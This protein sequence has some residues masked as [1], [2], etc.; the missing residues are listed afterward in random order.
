MRALLL[1][2]A[3]EEI[4]HRAVAF[5]VLRQVSPSYALRVAGLAMATALL[6]GFWLGGDRDA[7]PPGAAA[8][9]RA[10][11]HRATG[12]S[13][14][15][16][17]QATGVFVPGIRE[18][19]RPGFHPSQKD[20]DG[21]RRRVPRQRGPGLTERVDERTTTSSSSAPA[22]PASAWPSASS[23]PASHDFVILEQADG[24]GRHL[25]RQPLPR[26]RA[27]TWSRTSTRS[28]SS[29][30][31]AGRAPSPRR[32]RSSRTSSTART[33]TACARTSAS[34]RRVTRRLVRRARGG[35][36]RCRRPTGG[37][38]RARV[39]R[40]GGRGPLSRPRYPDIPGLSSFEGKI[41]PL[42][43]L[44]RRR[45]RSRARRSP[46]IGTGASAIQIVPAIAPEVGELFV[47][48]RTPPWIMPKP[49]RPHPRPRA[50]ALPPRRRPSQ[51][52]ARARH[53]LAARA[54]G[55]RLRRR[56]PHPGARRAA[57]RAATSPRSVADPAPAR[58]LAPSY[59]MGCKRVLLTNDY[60]PALQRENVE[61]VTEG[62]R[63][64][65]RP[66]RRDDATAASA[67]STPRARDGL[68]GGR[69]TSAPVR[70]RGRGGRDL[71]EAWRDGAEAYLGTTISGFP[72]LFLLV[73][74]NTGLGHTSMVFMIESQIAYV[75]DAIRDDA[76]ARARS[77][78][79][80]APDAQARYNELQARLAR[81]VWST[82]LHELVPD[83]RAGRTRRSGRAS[84][85]SSACARG[86]SIPRTTK[87][88]RSA[89]RPR[90]A[91]VRARAR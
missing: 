23:R 84:P 22:S 35:L 74:P 55:A 86:A 83:A 77:S 34:A 2:H 36:G 19:L 45:T 28:R 53:L 47:F 5:D 13:R 87:W 29:Q 65:R 56:A 17:A 60:Y 76:R 59:T 63:E 20:T 89:P 49:D 68:R 48:Q 10:R 70:V 72:N 37:R 27:A 43:A 58:K 39:A 30:T 80:S 46:S 66:R 4:E 32:R 40:L 82:G 42:G 8:S 90:L 14:A 51:K 31:R 44:G 79:T 25:A 3:A 9:P 67:R 78:S 50:R 64:V 71:D 6:G 52:L 33:S 75:L 18:Y 21:A 81:T 7:A 85:S 26:R 91:S 61:L 1:W 38:L 41:V 69:G 11:L 88:S 16:H 62:I 57:S 73:G 15:A 24:V 12:A 54:L